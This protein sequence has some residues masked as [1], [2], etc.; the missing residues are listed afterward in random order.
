MPLSFHHVYF[1]YENFGTSAQGSPRYQLRDLTFQ[2]NASEFVAIVG[3]SG[4]GKSTLQQMCNGLLPPA[5]GEIL[6]N[7]KNI[8][9]KGYDL[10]EL[11][12]RLGLVFQFPE[13]Q[14]FA[15][16]VREDVAFAPV[17]QK[18][19]LVEI[20]KRT[21][22]ALAQTGLSEKFLERNP[23]TLSEGEK[24]RVAF[25][26]VLAMQPEML[27]LDEPTA[28][29]DARGVLE[30]KTLL[31]Q[32]HRLGK[33]IVMIS[34]DADLVFAL[35]QRVLVLHE[36]AIIFDGAPAE[37]WGDEEKVNALC[38]RA[39]LA[40]PRAIRVRRQLLQ[41]GFDAALAEQAVA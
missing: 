17:Q 8:H 9:A 35:A 29:L 18:L 24:R 40:L 34:H 32:W 19:S 31:R 16:T 27:V 11:R 13:A 20:D 5:R 15:A 2:I 12:R 41:R 7:Q 23:L 30:V 25:A 39:G 1:A 28:S 14:L 36:G 10:A 21:H 38:S 22:E 4:S 33:T 37:L 6:F 26:G 3:R